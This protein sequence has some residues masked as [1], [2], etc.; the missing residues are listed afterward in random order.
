MARRAS[1]SQA[2]PPTEAGLI[3]LT[4]MVTVRLALSTF[5]MCTVAT[6]S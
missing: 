4:P 6:V 3:T 5:S 2:V 1:T